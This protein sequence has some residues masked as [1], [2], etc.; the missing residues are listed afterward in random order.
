MDAPEDG[1]SAKEVKFIEAM[2]AKTLEARGK[3]LDRL[4]SMK[5]ASFRADFI[6][7]WAASMT[8]CPAAQTGSMKPELKQW[9]VQRLSVLKQ[10]QAL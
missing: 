1:C 3:E 4:A 8:R 7:F 2:R 9:V 5:V 6:H 10:L